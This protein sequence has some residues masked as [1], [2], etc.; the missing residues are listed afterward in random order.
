MSI[1]NIIRNSTFPLRTLHISV[2]DQHVALR[3][4]A[5][6]TVDIPEGGTQML[7]QM[8]W[9][10]RSVNVKPTVGAAITIT[11]TLPDWYYIVALVAVVALSVAT[12]LELLERIYLVVF[13]VAFVAIAGGALFVGPYFR[14]GEARKR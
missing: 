4:R 5:S 13:V 9:W 1:V 12:A 11:H 2:G 8:D 3:G 14:V 7:M 10:R 6:A